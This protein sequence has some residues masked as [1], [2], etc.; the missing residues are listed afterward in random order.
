MLYML[1][2]DTCFDNLIF[3]SVNFQEVLRGKCITSYSIDL[4]TF[5]DLLI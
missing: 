2:F 1:F 3:R 4:D 5:Y